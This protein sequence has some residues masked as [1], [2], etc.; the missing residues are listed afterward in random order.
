M[1]ERGLDL[2]LVG[3]VEHRRR[4]VHARRAA[5]AAKRDDVLVVELVDE[6]RV[7]LVGRRSS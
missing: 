1:L 7:V 5:C 3:A 2:V 4:E 6:L